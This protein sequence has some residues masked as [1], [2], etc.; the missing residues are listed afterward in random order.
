MISHVI[1]YESSLLLVCLLG[2]Y[3]PVKVSGNHGNLWRA[4]IDS[5]THGGVGFLSW[6]V[7]IQAR[8]LRDFWECGIC[9]TVA[10]VIDADH[11]IAAPSFSLKVTS[12]IVE[13]YCLKSD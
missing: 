9:G 13:C 4:L 1:L 5:L 2:D 10:M 7:L 8:N 11:F 3:L 6:A 12:V